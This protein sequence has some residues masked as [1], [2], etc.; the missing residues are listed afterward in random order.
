MPGLV[1]LS[2]MGPYLAWLCQC[3]GV[4]ALQWPLHVTGFHIGSYANQFFS[5][6]LGKPNT[7]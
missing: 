7:Q 3:P 6:T 2:M 5:Q 4:G 1:S